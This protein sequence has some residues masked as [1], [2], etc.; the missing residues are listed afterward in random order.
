MPPK[1]IRTFI[2]SLDFDV[3]KQFYTDLGFKEY[4]IGD[5]MSYFNIDPNLGFYLQKYYVKEWLHNTM[6][7]VEVE[8]VH[9]H[10][11]YL[12]SLGLD[13]KYAGVRLSAVKDEDWGNV[14]F[15]H[16]PAGVLWHFA[17]F[18]RK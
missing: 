3:S 14:F 8:D 2:G 12:N 15:L 11:S 9:E 18:S 7:L 6:L 10:W 17:T 16:D 4:P 5:D 1:S 13:Q